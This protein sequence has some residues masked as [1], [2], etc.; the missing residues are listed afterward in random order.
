[1]DQAYKGFFAV[2][3]EQKQQHRHV[4]LQLLSEEYKH[5]NPDRYG[6]NRFCAPAEIAR[7]SGTTPKV[8]A[9]YADR[10]L[11]R[12]SRLTSGRGRARLFPLR[13]ALWLRLSAL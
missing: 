13:M 5:A 1:M 3:H 2:I 9:N 8:V 12:S 7:L 10:H 4:K 11:L 6:Y